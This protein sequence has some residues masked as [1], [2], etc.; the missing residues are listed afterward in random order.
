MRDSV[1]IRILSAVIITAL[2]GSM[3]NGLLG[4]LCLE[5]DG[6]MGPAD[7]YIQ[8]TVVNGTTG[9]K[10][11]ISTLDNTTEPPIRRYFNGSTMALG[12]FNIIVDSDP[13][14]LSPYE[15]RIFRTYYLEV[16]RDFYPFEESI[17][18]STSQVVPLG[19]LEVTPA[20]I[21]DLRVTILNKSSGE[22]LEGV[23]VDVDQG[24]GYPSIP[25]P[26]ANGTDGNGQVLYQSLLAV[27]TTVS[28]SIK[29]FLSLVNS[30]DI[31]WA[32]VEEG[33]VT[34]AVFYLK[35]K[36]WPF[37]TTPADGDTDVPVS[38]NITINFNQIMDTDTTENDD[39]YRIFRV[40]TDE[41]INFTARSHSLGMKADLDPD[42]DLEYNTTYGVR[43]DTGLENELGGRPLWRT[44]EFEFRTELRPGTVAGRIVDGVDSRGIPDV[45]M[46]IKDVET[47][48]NE[49]GFFLFEAVP[50]GDHSLRIDESYLYEGLL[51]EDVD[52]EKGMDLDLGTITLDRMAWGSLNVTVSSGQGPV[53]GAW[54]AIEGSGM[55]MTTDESGRVRFERT[56]IGKVTLTAGALHHDQVMDQVFVD[57]GKTVFLNIMLTEDELPVMVTPT[58]IISGRIVDPMTNFNLTMPGEINRETL[59]V[60]IWVT[61]D[62]GSRSEEIP[63]LPI[64]IGDNFNYTVKPVGSLPMERT[65][66]LIVRGILEDPDGS[67]ILWRDLTFDFETPVLPPSFIAG[68]ALLEGRPFEGLLVEFGGFGAETNSSGGFNISVDMSTEAMTSE[69]IIQANHLGYES[70]GMNLTID[71]GTVVDVDVISLIPLTGWYEVSPYDGEVDVSPGTNITFKFTKPLTEPEDGF[72]KYL[73]V[74]PDGSNAPLSGEYQILPG[75]RSVVFQPTYPLVEGD[76]YIVRTSPELRFT[77]GSHACPVGKETRFK[78]RNPAVVVSL[79]SPD[80]SKLQDAGIDLRIV[81]SFGVDVLSSSVEASLF[82]QPEPISIKFTWFTDAE[83]RMDLFL[84]S[85]MDYMLT[86]PAGSYGNGG[87]ALNSAYIL[88][89]KTGSHYDFDHTEVSF[90]INPDPRDGYRP[91]QEV[92]FNGL[93]E[94]STGYEVKI[95]IDGVGNTLT[96]T[97]T[98]SEDGSW[99]II[100]NAPNT[101]GQMVISLTIGIPGEISAIPERTWTVDLLEAEGGGDGGGPSGW[102]IPVIIAVAAVVIIVV[103]I[104]VVLT[105]K[106]REALEKSES[107]EYSDVDMEMEE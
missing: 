85:N 55:N 53:A 48:S 71:A 15:V 100:F 105:R 27:N 40:D 31:N 76:E 42:E 38:R 78:V 73:T 91:G 67:M 62:E 2:M 89:F 79:E 14:H 99:E 6:L 21:G 8:G 20:P 107:V 96:Y 86:L 80:Y 37:A 65:F 87:E 41:S 98:V 49:T 24:N 3:L 57:E 13:V 39:N 82:I 28:G 34:D 11:E 59:E 94:N 18:S 25:F 70:Y 64:T 44:M 26:T 66:V 88:A 103:V 7:A 83:A 9:I 69:L 63:L 45:N 35:E 54:V 97:D 58:R 16:V 19:E 52:V 90:S 43:L 50:S 101:T 22:P 32:V 72:S 74:H 29:N 92:R 30:N 33:I 106:N 93:M 46:R 1:K 4:P 77:D 75:N 95:T 10:V 17:N 51:V 104:A 47:R 36:Q 102:L 12:V 56:R 60:S 5:S 81:L 23:R 84:R 61:D 68:E